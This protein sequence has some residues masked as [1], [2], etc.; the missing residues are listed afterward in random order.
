MKK[1]K[2]LRIKNG[3][4]QEDLYKFLRITQPNYSN[5][6]NEKIRL[7][8]EYVLILSKFYNISPVYLID[9]SIDSPCITVAD[10]N[11]LAKMSKLIK[12]AKCINDAPVD[13]KSLELIKL[14]DQV[15]TKSANKKLP[16]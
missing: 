13:E 11:E 7:N 6:E 9:D 3:Y 15:E 2:F 4:S 10:L 8:L 1:L 14:I 5:F 16:I 12:N